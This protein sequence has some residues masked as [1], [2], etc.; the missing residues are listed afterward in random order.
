MSTARIR[1]VNAHGLSL[2]A[3][4]PIPLGKR[5]APAAFRGKP[6]AEMDAEAQAWAD[7]QPM[8]V[9]CCLCDDFEYTGTA[10]IARVQ[11]RLHRELS[12]PQARNRRGRR[13]VWGKT[14][15]DQRTDAEKAQAEID[16]AESNRVRHEKE[17]AERLEKVERGKRERA[18]QEREFERIAEG[19]PEHVRAAL[20]RPE[21]R[22]EF[23][24]RGRAA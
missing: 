17:E 20:R 2:G 4:V 10:G 24:K 12:H 11:A 3:A 9:S 21:Y 22:A 19:Q 15:S 8:T 7:E 16:R 14:R 5:E 18:A 6:A 1:D 23:L 13:R